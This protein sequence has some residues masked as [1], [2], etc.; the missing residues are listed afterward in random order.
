MCYAAL[1]SFVELFRGDYM[2]DHYWHGL[3]PGQVV[4]IGIF[5]AGALLLLT[6]PRKIPPAGPA[7]RPAAPNKP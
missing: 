2:R 5:L 6:L 3:T 7:P 1:R 4:S